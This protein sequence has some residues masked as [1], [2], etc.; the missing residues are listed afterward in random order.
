MLPTR[1]GVCIVQGSFCPAGPMMG[2]AL[3]APV[4]LHMVSCY[5]TVEELEVSVPLHKP[6]AGI[7]LLGTVL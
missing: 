4:S 6:L 2:W 3:D 1:T 7:F 5:S